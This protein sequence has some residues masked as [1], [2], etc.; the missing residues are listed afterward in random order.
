MSFL[1][2]GTVLQGEEFFLTYHIEPP[3]FFEEIVPVATSRS[4]GAPGRPQ[5]IEKHQGSQDFQDMNDM[6][7]LCQFHFQKDQERGRDEKGDHVATRHSH[8][9]LHEGSQPTIPT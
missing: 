1:K 6:P 3:D 9:F 7:S 4:S 2:S 5:Q 8:Q